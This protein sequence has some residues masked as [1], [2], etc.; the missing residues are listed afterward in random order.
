M[1]FS[2]NTNAQEDSGAD[3][4]R[5]KAGNVFSP[6]EDTARPRGLLDLGQTSRTGLQPDYIPLR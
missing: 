1:S 5:R 2:P 3:D 6:H 4:Q